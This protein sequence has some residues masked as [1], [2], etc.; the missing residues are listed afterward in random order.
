MG[1]HLSASQLGLSV[2][3]DGRGFRTLFTGSV[4]SL[5]FSSSLNCMWT[6]VQGRDTRR[7]SPLGISQGFGASLINP[8]KAD[9]CYLLCQL[10]LIGSFTGG[11]R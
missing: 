10:A 7:V 1:E 3:D 2:P 8:E 11:L 5:L 9:L 6:M 4:F